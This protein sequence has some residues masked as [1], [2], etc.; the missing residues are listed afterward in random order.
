MVGP[1]R[2]HAL[3]HAIGR[4]VGYW[5][6]SS[7]T[8]SGATLQRE[9]ELEHRSP[10]RGAPCRQTSAPIP[11]HFGELLR[12]LRVVAGL[13]QE[14]LAERAGLSAR[15]LS[16]LER[17]V[18]AAPRKDTLRLLTEA[19]ALGSGDRGALETAAQRSAA[20]ATRPRSI[21]SRAGADHPFPRA[22]LPI[23]ADP[24]VGRE[25]EVATVTALC[26][27]PSARLVTLTGPGGVGKTRLALQVAADLRTEF[28]SGVAFVPLAAIRDSA[29]VLPAVAQALGVRE[30][31]GRPPD[32]ALAVALRGRRML[33]VLDNFEQVV[34]AA[35]AVG[36]L[37]AACP[38]LRILATSRVPLRLSSEQRYLVPPLATPDSAPDQAAD[39]LADN[40]A[41]R[42]FVRRARQVR[43]DLTLT[44]EITAAAA[45]I[46]R[47]L[48]G[49]PLAIELAAARIVV[50]PPPAL[51]ARL[52]RALPV[53]SGGARDQPERLR[54]MREAIAWSYEL[55]P[56]AAQA[57]FRQLA[58][59]AG[60]FTLEAATAV[61]QAEDDTEVALFDG[62]AGLVEASL[63]R[64]EVGLGGEPRFSM[65]ETIREYGV[66]RLAASSEEQLTQERHAAWVLTFAEGAEPE[67]FRA[68]QQSWWRRLEAE[69]PNIRAA[70]DWFE[71]TG[72]AERAL[73]L[74]GALTTFNYML[75]HFEE[76]QEWLRR[77]L[78]VPGETSSTSRAWAIIGLGSLAWFRGDNDTARMLAGQS[79]AIARDGDSS[80]AWACRCCC[81]RRS[82]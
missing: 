28:G 19:L 55:L 30:I 25:S 8:V 79:L 5:R 14:A 57:L 10:A 16:D 24:L 40:P 71:Q 23:S 43:P 58:V 63:L 54:T 17:G 7:D 32:D 13:T 60:G 52:E 68:D 73:R 61:S 4:G 49:L 18:R 59:F 34:S 50:L 48:D 3:G 62:V 42:L 41:L 65:L 70:L 12:R 64:S 47:R 66:E 33:L 82:R 22:E 46:C 11:P 15:G 69:R 2:T 78:A 51:L 72:D 75:G 31:P 1:R 37:L 9:P 80:S 56:S 76:G 38:E 77:A 81:L 36:R 45:S 21:G 44:P 29:L 74:A 6:G 39:A 67:L 35:P 26:R 53:L 27:D 20:A